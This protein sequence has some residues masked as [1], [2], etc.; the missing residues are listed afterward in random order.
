MLNIDWRS[1]LLPWYLW[2]MKV[3]L[4]SSLLD[5]LISSEMA[6]ILMDFNWVRKSWHNRLLWNHVERWSLCDKISQPAVIEKNKNVV[7][8]K[9]LMVKYCILP[10]FCL[11]KTGK[12]LEKGEQFQPVIFLIFAHSSWKTIFAI[13]VRQHYDSSFYL[14]FCIAS[15]SSHFY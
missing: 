11:Q 6:M 9:I 7:Q 8:I 12:K 2:K 13:I 1:V 10:L 5:I 14:Y 15:A 3:I 4:S